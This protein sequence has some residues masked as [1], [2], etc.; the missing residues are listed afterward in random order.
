MEP[1]SRTALACCWLQ[2]HAEETVAPRCISQHMWA[3]QKAQ[4]QLTVQRSSS[5]VAAL[6]PA[7]LGPRSRPRAGAAA[8]PAVLLLGG[9]GGG[10]LVRLR[11]LLRRRLLLLLL[12]RCRVRLR[13]SCALSMQ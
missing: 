4:G 5:L 2:L 10:R 13:R 7:L 12:L 3:L 8:L 11:G 6:L 1:L 9:G